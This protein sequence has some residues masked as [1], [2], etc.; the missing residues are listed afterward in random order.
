AGNI[1][2][3]RSNEALKVN[4]DNSKVELNTAVSNINTFLTAVPQQVQFVVNESYVTIQEVTNN[5]DAIGLKL[6]REIQKQFKSTFTPALQSLVTMNQE[7][8]NTSTL[9][10]RLNTSLNNLESN[11]STIKGNI[12][13]LKK[14][15]NE[16][17]SRPDCTNCDSVKPE[18]NK[19]TVDTSID[20]RTLDDLQTAMNEIIKADLSS[21]VREVKVEIGKINIDFTEHRTLSVYLKSKA[22]LVEIKYQISN[23][24]ADLT[25]PGLNDVLTQLEHLQGNID[26]YSPEI[27]QAEYIRWCVCIALCCVIL[28]VVVCNLLGLS[29]GPLGLKSKV[30]PTKRSCVSDCGGTFF[31]IGA[32]FSFIISWLFMILVLILF[33]IGGNAYTL[34]C[35][36][37]NN[38]ELFQ[39][40]DT[41]GA[42][43]GFD[44]SATLGAN[45][46]ISSIYRDCE[47]NKPVW[48]VFQL[49]QKINLD[50]LLNV[51]KYTDEIKKN[52]ENTN[53]NL[54]TVNFLT[55]EVKDQLKSFSSKA[56]NIDFETPVQQIN[57]MSKINLNTTADKL[58][59]LARNKE[60]KDE[61]QSLRNIQA[62]IETVIFP[63]LVRIN[64]ST[65][66]L[67]CYNNP[68]SSSLSLSVVKC[69]YLL[70]ATVGEV[71]RSVGVAQ[72]F[73]NKNATQIV[74]TESGHFL[75]CQL[76]YFMAFAD[77]AKNTITQEMGRCGPVAG[78]VDS[79]EIIVCSNMVESLNAFWFSLGWCMI[80]LIPS[81]ILTIKLAK[82]YRKMKYT[83][84]FE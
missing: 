61:A 23:M 80:F 76:E 56:D 11:T 25:L 2:M 12:T 63:Q 73:F 68:Y 28:L 48:T 32:G 54:P 33:L 10:N 64:V 65:L 44:L 13:V 24:S 4:V 14:Q 17:L 66:N 8:V 20:A 77:F 18:L 49:S 38:G 39:V 53:I 40:L 69:W 26:M 5:L 19:L 75:D 59:Q 58:D 46:T 82:Y 31:M 21:K 3:F 27:K 35:K 67:N 34:L 9:L 74:K 55:Q 1:C 72:D 47:E 50:D 84:V 45:I 60:L 30:E 16:T 83:D 71:L 22:Q 70:Q 81:I 15:I 52:F 78:A 42:I 51:S 79:A 43:P 6:G 37:W 62:D 7:V 36:P 41:A 57:N 29:L